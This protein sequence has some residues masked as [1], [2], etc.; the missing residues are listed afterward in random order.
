MKK[1]LAAMVAGSL[2]VAMSISTPAHA[3]DSKP[4]PVAA[5]A[6]AWG[7]SS[8]LLC[9]FEDRFGEGAQHDWS[10]PA[11]TCV[12]VNY[13]WYDRMASA[14]NRLPGNRHVRLHLNNN[15][16]G[17]SYVLSNG[18]SVTFNPLH[19]LYEKVSSFALFF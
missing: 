14:S 5:S 3:A 15:C 17:T 10:N 11:G 18:N 8:G 16:T 7:C 1:I 9:F 12:N 6:S 2:L 19:P 13:P 4:A